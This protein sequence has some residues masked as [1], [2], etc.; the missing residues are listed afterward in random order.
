[1]HEDIEVLAAAAPGL[2]RELFA[3]LVR[4]TDVCF[5]GTLIRPNVQY[6]RRRPTTAE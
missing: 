3:K 4:H 5:D 2:H 1:V 6:G